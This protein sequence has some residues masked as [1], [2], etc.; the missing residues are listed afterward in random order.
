VAFV[1]VGTGASCFEVPPGAGPIP[2]PPHARTR[3]TVGTSRLPLR[4]GP[5]G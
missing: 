4:M 1:L 2:V 3:A 5:G